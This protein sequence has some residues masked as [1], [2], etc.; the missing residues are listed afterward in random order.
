MADIFEQMVK[1]VANYTEEKAKEAKKIMKQVINKNT[2]ALSDS[3]Q[4]QKV[5]ATHYRVGVNEDVLVNDER[6]AGNINYVK[7]Y[8]HGSKPHTIRAKPGKVLHW[9][10][11]GKDYF[12]K[13]VKH[14]GSKPHDFITETIK[15]MK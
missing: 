12:A 8:F 7:F 5:S 10:K 11:N 1:D 15:K 4:I 6:N 3:V 9:K 13:T 14:P 2:G